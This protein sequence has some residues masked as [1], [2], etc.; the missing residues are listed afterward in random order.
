M[1]DSW[2]TTLALTEIYQHLLVRCHDSW[3]P[4]I[5]IVIDF[6]FV[7]T[8]RSVSLICDVDTGI[9]H[10]VIWPLFVCNKISLI[11]DV[12]TGISHQVIWPLFVCNKIT[13]QSAFVPFCSI[14]Y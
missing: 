3:Y 9:S 6:P 4:F 11:C 5:L 7:T 13:Q 10:Q 2:V 12:D 1:L 8:M 14:T